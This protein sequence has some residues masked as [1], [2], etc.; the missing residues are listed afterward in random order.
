M[1][2]KW[3]RFVITSQIMEACTCKLRLGRQLVS[4][5]QKCLLQVMI[6]ALSIILYVHTVSNFCQFESCTAGSFCGFRSSKSFLVMSKHL[7][8]TL[9]S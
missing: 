2:E 1:V 9:L 6:K 5:D 4:S 3:P 8:D 7:I